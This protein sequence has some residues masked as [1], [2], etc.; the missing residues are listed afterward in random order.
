MY[1]EI[2]R[3]RLFKIQAYFIIFIFLVNSLALKLYF[4][5]SIWYF[6]MFMH[7]LGGFWVALFFIWLSSIKNIQLNFSSESFLKI[8]YFVLFIGVSWE[9]FEIIF[10]NVIAQNEF[11]TLD[12]LSDLFF[13]FSGAIFASLF[14]LKKLC[15]N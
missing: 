3:K 12:S 10:N 4:Y 14:F 7:F 5:Y 2:D 8:T 1:T 13:D 15:Y 9:I 6:D 11:N